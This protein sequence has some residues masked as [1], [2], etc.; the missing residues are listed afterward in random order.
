MPKQVPIPGC[1]PG[2]EYMCR[3]EEV[4]IEKIQNVADCKI[5]KANDVINVL[6]NKYL[7]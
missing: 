4:W 5:K 6:L 7:T 3:L 1:P 2:L